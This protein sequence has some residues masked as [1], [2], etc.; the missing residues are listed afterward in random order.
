MVIEVF[1]LALMVGADGI[2]QRPH[3]ASL[4]LQ[5]PQIQQALKSAVTNPQ[6]ADF[7]DLSS[8]SDENG[9]LIM[10]GRVSEKTAR[11]GHQPLRPF[12][13]FVQDRRLKMV[14]SGRGRV[15]DQAI[16]ARCSS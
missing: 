6:A 14:I 16:A 4:L 13:L 2:P 11:G 1:A 12:V 15:G 5:S 3:H 7:S 9:D 8:R 10:C